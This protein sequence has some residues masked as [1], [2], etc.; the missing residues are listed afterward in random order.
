[1]ASSVHGEPRSSADAVV[2]VALEDES[3]PEL[4]A[5]LESDFYISETAVRDAV[6]RRSSF[7]VF[8]LET[9]FKGDVFVAGDGPLDCGQ[10]A[11]RC[12]VEL[13]GVP[14]RTGPQGENTW[15]LCLRLRRL[16]VLGG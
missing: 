14:R 2:V 8:D 10:L 3:V 12:V 11:R 5:A 6:L 16:R 13:C 4:M 7:N 9:F 15:S 1:M